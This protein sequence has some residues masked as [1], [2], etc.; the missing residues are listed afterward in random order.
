MSSLT[1]SIEAVET[2]RASDIEK[3]QINAPHIF[4]VLFVLT[5]NRTKKVKPDEESI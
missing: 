2:T 3:A 1:S 5:Q 4:F